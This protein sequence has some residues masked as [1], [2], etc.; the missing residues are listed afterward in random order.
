MTRE[1]KLAIVI[2]FGLLLFVGILVSDH[3]SARNAQIANPQTEVARFERIAQDPKDGSKAFLSASARAPTPPPALPI[4]DPTMAELR[5]G[6]ADG[7][8]DAGC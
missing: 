3:L 8:M 2:G 7:Q 5:V 4:A 6:S 1:N